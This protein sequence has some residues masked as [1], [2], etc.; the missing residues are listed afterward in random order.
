MARRDATKAETRARIVA[1]T[2]RLY[3]ERGI[4]GATVPA[5]ARAADVAPATVRNHFPGPTDLA[6][7]AAQSILDELRM[8]DERI[9]DGLPG[10]IERVLQ[11]LVEVAAFFERSTGWWEV[12]EADR[13]AGNAWATPEAAY[14]DR[15]GALIRSAVRPLDGDPIAVSVIG[16]VLVHVYFAMRSTGTSTD[17]AIAAEAALLVPWLESRLAADGPIRPIVPPSGHGS[18]GDRTRS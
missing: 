10:T 15:F 8:P 6:Q 1:A 17:D 2:L 14:E 7:A 18:R 11:L 16:A 3:R 5:V 9:F 4:A 12:R 13:I